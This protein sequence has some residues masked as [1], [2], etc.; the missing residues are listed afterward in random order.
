M[1]NQLLFGVN[2]FNQTFNDANHSFDTA[3]YGLYLSPDALIN[4]QPILGAPNIADQRIRAGRHHARRKV[5]MTS[6][7]C[8]PTS[9]PT[10]SASISSG[11]AANFARATWTNFTYRHSFGSSSLMVR[12]GRGQ[13]IA[14]RI[15]TL[16][17]AQCLGRKDPAIFALADFLAGYVSVIGIA[18][19]NAERKVVVNGF[20]FFAQ[21]SWQVTRRLNFNWGLRWDYFGPLH[22]GTKD[23]AVFVPSG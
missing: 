11:S 17:D 13:P 7:A 5:A 8:W 21:D 12:R 19:G 16:P 20:D 22:N 14:P 18:V 3:S 4:G 1:T 15:Q 2:Y 10:T 9:S 6:P 23:L